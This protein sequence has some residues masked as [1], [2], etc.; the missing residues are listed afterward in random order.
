MGVSTVY[1]IIEDSGKQFMVQKG[2]VILVDRKDVEPGNEIKFEQVL[3]VD[4]QVGF[5]FVEGASV[6]GLVRRNV[7]DAK[8]TVRKFKRR[9]K[10]R[11]CRGHRQKYTQVEIME[12]V[13]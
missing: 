10:Y 9:K 8:V 1:A 4:G 5:P 6:S 12:I 11:R 3:C 13:S 7:K 2:N